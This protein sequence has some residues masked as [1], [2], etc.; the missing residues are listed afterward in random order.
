MKRDLRLVLLQK[1][2]LLSEIYIYIYIYKG[3]KNQKRA[4]KEI[5]RA[6]TSHKMVARRQYTSPGLAGLCVFYSVQKDSSMEIST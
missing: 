3:A 4:R 5:K 6:I 2:V 1:Y